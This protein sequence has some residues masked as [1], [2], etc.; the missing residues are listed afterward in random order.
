MDSGRM[1]VYINTKSFNF[2]VYFTARRF[3]ARRFSSWQSD[4]W[5]WAMTSVTQGFWQGTVT[6]SWFVT[7]GRTVYWAIKIVRLTEELRFHSETFKLLATKYFRLWESR[8][9]FAFTLFT[10]LKRFRCFILKLFEFHRCLRNYYTWIYYKM[11]I[12]FS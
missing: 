11:R 6:T 9:W 1:Y 12:V 8:D 2:L 7:P 5:G 10:F 3:T 4:E